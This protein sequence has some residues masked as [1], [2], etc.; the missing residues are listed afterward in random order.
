MELSNTFTVER[1]PAETW[2]ALQDLEQMALCMPGATLTSVDGDAFTGQVTVR[3][4]PMMMTYTGEGVIED[5]HESSRVLTLR[6]RGKEAK[7]SGTAAALVRAALSED[8]ANGTRVEV[9]TELDLTGKPAQ[10]GRGVLAEVAGVVISRFARNLADR[11]QP[12]PAP[13]SAPDVAGLAEASPRPVP[14]SQ[15]VEDALDLGSLTLTML[16]ERKNGMLAV[17][18]GVLALLAFLI[19]R[20]N[21][22][23]AG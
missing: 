6:L 4:G 19:G 8:G 15:P 18:V 11:L 23:R 10:F 12:V 1:G 21:G 13:E 17:G 16:K 22:K 9:V 3:V 20:R 2:E 7:G 14:E 5:R